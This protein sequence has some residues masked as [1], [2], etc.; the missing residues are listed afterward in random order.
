MSAHRLARSIAYCRSAGLLDGER[1]VDGPRIFPEPGGDDLDEEPFAVEDL[2][3]LVHATE[4]AGP[5]QVGRHDVVVV[6]LHGIEAQFLVSPAACGR[7]PSP[8]APSGRTGRP[9]C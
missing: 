4:G 8:G 9:R 3:D 5:V 1:A 2:L 6:K 7:I